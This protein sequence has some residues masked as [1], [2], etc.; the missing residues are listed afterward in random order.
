MDNLAVYAEPEVQVNIDLP[1]YAEPLFQ[2]YRYKVLYGGR[3]SSKS[4]TVARV[5]LIKGYNEVRRVLC[6]REFQNSISESVHKLLSEQIEAMGLQHHYTVTDKK[7]VGKNGT[8]FIFKGV[9][10]N[11]ESIKSMQGITDLWLEEAQTVSQDSWDVLIPTIRAEGSEIW[12]T[13]NPLNDDDPTYTKFVNED[14]TP[15]TYKGLL[16]LEVNW[17]DNPWFPDVLKD[18]KDY[19]FEVDPDLAMHVW[20]GRCKK[21][22]DAQI[23]KGKWRVA[24]F[25]I[26]PQWEGPYLGA[27]W[28]FSVDPTVL[29]ESYIDF[30]N[31]VL[32]VSAEAYGEH[33]ELDDIPELFDK[34]PTSRQRVSRGDNSRPETISHLK[35]KGFPIEAC[36]KWKGCV[37][38]GIEKIRS[39]REI[40]IHVNCPNMANEARLYSFKTDRLTNE[41]T[42][43]IIDADNHCWDALRYALEPII[44]ADGMGLLG[45][46]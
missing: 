30:E 18:E 29:I 40:V 14:H 22:S 24:D 28:G 27:D 46:L 12:V 35:R 1:P 15:K 41:V 13:F 7:I 26:Q 2:P 36:Q 25:E 21:F 9:K 4:Y 42:T 33:V 17:R 37:E 6:A 19:L 34:I 11:T 43:K 5:L 3:G 44:I 45:H 23:F 8:E 20:E 38:D 31:M 10:S 16:C 39:F 32:Y